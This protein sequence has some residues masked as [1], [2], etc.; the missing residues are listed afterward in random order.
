IEIRVKQGDGQDGLR[1][2]D[3]SWRSTSHLSGQ[4]IRPV[5]DSLNLFVVEVTDQDIMC[6]WGP[7]PPQSP[8]GTNA[9]CEAR[10]V[11]KAQEQ[12]AASEK[13]ENP[14]F[15]PFPTQGR[16]IIH[17]GDK[18]REAGFELL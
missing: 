17:S 10:H 15:W 3:S 4:G 11:D 18:L 13:P 5:T 12:G 6:S 2:E 8:A 16:P 14:L 1:V 7:A 9:T